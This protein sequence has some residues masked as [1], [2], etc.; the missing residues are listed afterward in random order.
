MWQ[1]TLQVSARKTEPHGFFSTQ[2][3]ATYV[4]STL[5]G[6]DANDGNGPVCGV[7]TEVDI[8]M[9]TSVEEY[10]ASLEQ[11]KELNQRQEWAKFYEN[12][13]DHERSLM[14]KY[15]PTSIQDV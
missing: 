10:Q 2:E 12:L 3:V 5:S 4:A 15:A 8:N 7:V 11:A 14:T 6:Y 1:V 13:T 9:S